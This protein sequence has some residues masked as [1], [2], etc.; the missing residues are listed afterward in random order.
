L[1]CD[2]GATGKLMKKAAGTHPPCLKLVRPLSC[3][4][5]GRKI[6]MVA[7][8]AELSNSPRQVLMG[9]GLEIRNKIVQP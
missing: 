9:E 2:D 3:R 7:P 4:T 8:A 5:R 6:D 1:C